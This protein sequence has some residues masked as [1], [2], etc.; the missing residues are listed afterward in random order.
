MIWVPLAGVALGAG[1]TFAVTWLTQK[2]ESGRH[3]DREERARKL[4]AETRLRE[5]C[6]LVLERAADTDRALKD[7]VMVYDQREPH[8]M[9]PGKR[10][11]ELLERVS[12][13]PDDL[14]PVRATLM[15]DRDGL[16]VLEAFDTFRGWY[17]RFRVR[18]LT[19]LAGGGDGQ[20]GDE[21]LILGSEA[22]RESLERVIRE[23]LSSLEKQNA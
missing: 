20:A 3:R 11:R 9:D 8:Q 16:E 1:A 21:N 12:Q 6:A 4:A 15:L 17:S 7:M 19:E 5:S 10:R 23:R 14:G 13:N 22:D 2:G 18:V